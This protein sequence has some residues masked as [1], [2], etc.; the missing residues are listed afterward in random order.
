MPDP[1]AEALEAL[2][3]ATGHCRALVREFFDTFV[4][5]SLSAVEARAILWAS[6]QRSLA[7]LDARDP[8]LAEHVAAIDAALFDDAIRSIQPDIEITFHVPPPEATP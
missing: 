2:A 6:I 8:R 7:D 1:T 4:P 5:H 3:T